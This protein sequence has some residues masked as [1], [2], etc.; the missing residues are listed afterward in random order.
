MQSED[1]IFR[2]REIEYECIQDIKNVM[3]KYV[4]L[5][6]RYTRLADKY[7]DM[8]DRDYNH[9]KQSLQFKWLQEKQG[10]LNRIKKLEGEN[11]K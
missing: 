3:A 6:D 5:N 9:A 2:I 4:E 11:A 10:L 8:K 7:I 1:E